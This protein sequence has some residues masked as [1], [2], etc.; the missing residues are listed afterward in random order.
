MRHVDA[1][2]LCLS[3]ENCCDMNS[4]GGKCLE[5]AAQFLLHFGG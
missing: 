1:V 2:L 3:D 4:K 5:I